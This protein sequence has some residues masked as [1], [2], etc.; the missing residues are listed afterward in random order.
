MIELVKSKNPLACALESLTPELEAE[1][2]PLLEMNHE[3]TPLYEGA[4]LNVNYGA[5]R[6]LAKH[7]ILRI[8]TLRSGEV[9][10]PKRLVGYAIFVKGPGIHDQAQTIA[11]CDTVF[12]M[13]LYRG[14][15][16]AQ[17]FLSQAIQLLEKEG[18]D[19]ID[20]SCPAHSPLGAMLT[21]K[22]DFAPAT[23]TLVKVVKHGA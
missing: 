1:I 7:G 3:E 21:I 18:V 5:Y 22:L 14:M 19:R 9:D 23:M 15:T 12:I 16:T 13:K 2:Q 11:Q 6:Q 4:V 20:I 10:G 8:F 17:R